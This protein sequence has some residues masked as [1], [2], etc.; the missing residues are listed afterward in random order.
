MAATASR[1]TYAPRAPVEERRKQLLDA[2]LKLV[3]SEGHTAATMEAVARQAGVS[4]P[5]IYGV[6]ANRADLLDALLRREQEEGL[7]QVAAVVPDRLD[8]AGDLGAQLARIVDDLLRAVRAAPER[9]HC[10]VMPMPDMPAQFHA[11]REY[12]RTLV[13]HRTEEMAGEFLRAA[14]A[15]PD[16]SPDLVAHAVIALFEMAARLV[17]TAP[18]K[19]SPER[20]TATVRAALNH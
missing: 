4:K 9:W 18:E 3:V 2:A 6:Y 14:G 16:L 5:V 12:A 13:L 20:I 11:A 17:L 19:Y 7:R 15:S 1:R 8:P 10:I